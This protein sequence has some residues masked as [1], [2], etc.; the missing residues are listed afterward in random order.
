MVSSL[1]QRAFHTIQIDWVSAGVIAFRDLM[2]SPLH[3]VNHKTRLFDKCVVVSALAIVG[4]AAARTQGQES[5]LSGPS[6][7][8]DGHASTLAGWHTLGQASW[9]ADQGEIVGD[10]TNAAGWLVLDRS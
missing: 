2:K 6:F 3:N 9:R 7:I 10:G 5:T 4:I 1:Y 8:P